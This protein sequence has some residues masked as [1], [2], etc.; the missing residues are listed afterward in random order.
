MLSF[1]TVEQAR[2][3]T[4]T[5]SKSAYSVDF[6]QRAAC[7]VV[8]VTV[9]LDSK[10]LCETARLFLMFPSKLPPFCSIANHLIL[11][12]PQGN[13]NN[14]PD[15]EAVYQRNEINIM[16]QIAEANNEGVDCLAQGQTLT[17]IHHFMMA[18]AAAEE[19]ARDL[20]LIH[21][22]GGGLSIQPEEVLPVEIPS[23]AETDSTALSICNHAF[24]LD[25]SATTASDNNSAC[26]AAY[27]I[28]LF[29]LSLSMHSLLM[30]CPSDAPTRSQRALSIYGLSLQALTEFNQGSVKAALVAASKSN[31]AQIHLHFNDRK[32]VAMDLLQTLDQNLDRMEDPDPV[33]SKQWKE[34]MINV[35]TIEHLF[36]ISAPSA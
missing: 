20:N 25:P 10:G 1:L 31:Q 18:V 29:N 9:V 11:L 5:E 21:A 23:L 3:A 15:H 14:S 19:L 34:I 32:D 8:S 24:L 13:S 6:V 27:V 17:A 28:P 12:V 36:T 33:L 4:Y 7:V 2:F 22:A 35:V 16:N 26:Q 30:A